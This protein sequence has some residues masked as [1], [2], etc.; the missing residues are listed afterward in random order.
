MRKDRR[1]FGNNLKVLISKKGIKTKDFAKN[2][3][4]TEYELC[5]IMDARLILDTDE[6]NMIADTLGVSVD[7]LYTEMESSEYEAAGCM[8][9]R[10]VF[11]NPE[12]EKLILDLFDIY[13]DIQERIAEEQM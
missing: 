9:Y 6:E 11:S 8:E 13:C 12:N 1:L 7:A 10:G 4:C 2:M 5:K 3:N